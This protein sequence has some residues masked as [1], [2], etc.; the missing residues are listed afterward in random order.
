MVLFGIC[1]GPRLD[2]GQRVF[3]SRGM[4]TCPAIL[5]RN[6]SNQ[7]LLAPAR[8]LLLFGFDGEGAF[9]V[10]EGDFGDGVGDGRRVAVG[11]HL[12][13]RMIR[14]RRHGEEGSVV[15]HLRAG[16][17]AHEVDVGRD[18]GGSEDA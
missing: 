1:Q 7:G 8:G 5:D 4:P 15:N 3:S 12:L 9:A 6:W 18:P 11:R 2:S 16:G 17:E 13:L 10:F 14:D